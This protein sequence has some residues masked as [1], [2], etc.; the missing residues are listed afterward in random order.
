MKIKVCKGCGVHNPINNER[1][2]HCDGDIFHK[3][4]FVQCPYCGTVEEIT[5]MDNSGINQFCHPCDPYTPLF[6]GGVFGLEVAKSRGYK[7]E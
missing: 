6:V 7:G 1:C 2:L 5:H 3:R 4:E